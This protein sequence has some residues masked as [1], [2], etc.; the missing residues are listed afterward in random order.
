MQLKRR[1]WVVIF[2]R[3]SHPHGNTMHSRRLIAA[4]ITSLLSAMPLSELYAACTSVPSVGSE[5]RICSN[6]TCKSESIW[7]DNRLV[8]VVYVECTG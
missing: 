3:L 5:R 6:G 7:Q 1:V 4:G 2:R 8:S